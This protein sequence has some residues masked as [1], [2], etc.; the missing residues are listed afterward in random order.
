MASLEHLPVQD[1]AMAGGWKSHSVVQDIYQ[2][3]DNAGILKAVL[4]PKALWGAG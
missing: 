2:Q 3:A 4:E 1:V